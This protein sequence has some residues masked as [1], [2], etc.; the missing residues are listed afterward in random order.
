M[1]QGIHGID[2]FRWFAG[3]LSQAV[4]FTATRYWKIAPLEDNAF[5]LFRT[6]E[7]QIASLHSS[8]T[9]WKNHFTFEIYGQEGYIRAEGLG[10]SYGV[11]QVALGKRSFQEPFREDVIEFRGEDRSWHEEWKEFATSISE[12][13]E[14]MGDGHD[15]LEALKLVFA[16]YQS[17]ITNQVVDVA[18]FWD[19]K[20]DKKVLKQGGA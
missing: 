6:P 16:V 5:A 20:D 19:T 2:L 12:D 1:E 10:A 3:D 4:G 7:G 11:E 17:A 9:Q 18:D 14:P 8:L 15:G 13:R